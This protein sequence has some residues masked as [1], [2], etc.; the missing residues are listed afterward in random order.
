MNKLKTKY[1]D[2]ARC[3]LESLSLSNA[4]PA[5]HQTLVAY[6]Y[7]I[8]NYENLKNDTEFLIDLQKSFEMRDRKIWVNKWGLESIEKVIRNIDKELKKLE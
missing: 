7:K 1:N 6:K 4:L 3:K 8:K 5:I 2:L